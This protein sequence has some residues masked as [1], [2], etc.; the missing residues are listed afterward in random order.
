MVELLLEVGGDVNEPVQIYAGRTV[1]ELY[2]LFLSK[3][4]IQSRQYCKTTWLLINHGAKPTKACVAGKQR[5][6]TESPM[7]EIL[8]KAFGEQEAENMCERISKN[9]VS[10]NWWSGLSDWR[11]WLGDST[12]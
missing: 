9:E 6:Q 5:G 8:A 4:K 3:R 7:K 12:Q 10:G 1:W 11:P 2:L